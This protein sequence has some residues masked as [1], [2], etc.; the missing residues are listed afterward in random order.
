MFLVS[1]CGCRD[2]GNTCGVSFLK[3]TSGVAFDNTTLLRI[4]VP[5]FSTTPFAAPSEPTRTWS[6]S[7]RRAQMQ[8]KPQLK[9]NRSTVT[10]EPKYLLCE[11]VCTVRSSGAGDGLRHLAHASLHITPCTFL[12]LQLAH[13]MVEQHIPSTQDRNISACRWCVY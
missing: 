12:L 2:L 3:V 9:I 11:N 8:M 5:S 4:S 1:L 13:H 6:T 7:C 10:S